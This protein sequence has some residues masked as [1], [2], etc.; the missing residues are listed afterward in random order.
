MVGAMMMG[1]GWEVTAVKGEGWEVME[2]MVA[3]WEMMAEMGADWVTMATGEGWVVAGVMEAAWVVVTVGYW[4]VKMIELVK[5][6]SVDWEGW[7]LGRG[8]TGRAE[9]S[10][11]VPSGSLSCRGR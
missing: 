3:A 11:P 9:K 1:V 10:I 2:V 4:A 8:G 5:S 6:E 7:G